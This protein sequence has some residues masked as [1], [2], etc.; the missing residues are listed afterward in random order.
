MV[1]AP[2]CDRG[3]CFHHLNLRIVAV[4]LLLRELEHSFWMGAGAPLIEAT[5]SP[6][7]FVYDGQLNS[8]GT[9][10]RNLCRHGVNTL[11]MRSQVGKMCSLER[12]PLSDR[13]QKMQG[14]SAGIYPKAK[15]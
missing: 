7:V 1:G 10:R 2:V 5:R 9:I 11:L 13:A 12:C 15:R 4:P 8:V 3:Y 14:F 6:F